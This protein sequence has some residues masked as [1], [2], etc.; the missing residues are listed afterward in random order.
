MRKYVDLNKTKFYWNSRIEYQ[1][2]FILEYI[3]KNEITTLVSIKDYINLVSVFKDYSITSGRTETNQP[4]FSFAGISF[5]M[6]TSEE[7][8]KYLLLK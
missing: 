4:T 5:I 2:N 6:L 7:T 1:F 8:E 3:V